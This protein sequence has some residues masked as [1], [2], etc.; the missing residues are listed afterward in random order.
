LNTRW[1]QLWPYLAAWLGAILAALAL[2]ALTRFETQ[3]DL[4]RNEHATRREL[5]N[6][7]RLTQEHAS[8]TLHA[9]DQA[10]QLVR[11]LYLRDGMKLDLVSNK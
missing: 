6:L 9:A 1:K 8:R 3:E 5:S 10:L 4:Q 7:T 11:A 2:L